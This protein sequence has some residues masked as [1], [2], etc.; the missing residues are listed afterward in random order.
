M[1]ENLGM[2][3]DQT[4]LA[5]SL[6]GEKEV[7]GVMLQ[8]NR[9]RLTIYIHPDDKKLHVLLNGELIQRSD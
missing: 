8:F 3:I 5:V 7:E 4:L 1:T 6:L 9:D 2:L